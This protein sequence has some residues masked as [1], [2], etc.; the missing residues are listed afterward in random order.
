LDVIYVDC[1]THSVGLPGNG[2]KPTKKALGNKMA[3]ICS[4]DEWS[5]IEFRFQYHMTTMRPLFDPL[6]CLKI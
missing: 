2:E 4:I 5:K 6:A 3:D 1:G